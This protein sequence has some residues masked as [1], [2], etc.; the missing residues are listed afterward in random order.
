MISPNDRIMI[1]APHPDDE[2]LCT[3]GV[4]QQALAL[5][6]PIRVVFFTYGDNNEWSFVV[7][8]KRLTVGSKAVEGMGQVRHDEAIKATGILGLAPEQ[9]TFLGYPDFGTLQIWEKH[10]GDRPAFRSMF[11]RME[12]VRYPNAFRPGAAYRG[13]EILNDLK[14][15]LSDFR[16]T[17]VFLSHP[18]DHNPDHQALY[19][20]T[21]VALWDLAAELQPE[22][23]PFLVHYPK[24]PQRQGF[25]PTWRLDPPAELADTVPWHSNPL[26]AAEAKRKTEAIQA[27]ATQYRVSDKFLI[28]FL[29]NNELFGDYLPTSLAYAAPGGAPAPSSDAGTQ[30]KSELLTASQRARFVGVESRSVQLVEDR[31]VV[32]INFSGLLAGGVEAA[33][34]ACGYRSDRP[35]AEMPKLLIK[36]SEVGL[37]VFNN[38]EKLK[39]TPVAAEHRARHFAIGIPLALLGDPHRLMGSAKTTMNEYPLDSAPWRIFDLR[40]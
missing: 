21:R 28:T 20:F 30:R 1:L 39:G 31:L 38:G 15:L 6:I 17:K 10:W 26:S 16:P 19:L 18:A 5:G 29:R 25:D 22:L 40:G 3:A 13:E 11:G 4:I 34:Y 24:W 36:F 27:H 33:I 9:V 23:Y 12:A 7:Y 35:F 8:R 32:A 2:T 14:R 37:D